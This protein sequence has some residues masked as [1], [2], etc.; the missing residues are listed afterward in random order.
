MK[1]SVIIPVYN[2]RDTLER[3]VRSVSGQ[4]FAD[5]EMILVDDGSSDGSGVLAETLAAEDDRMSVVHQENRGISAARNTGL[6]LAEG[7]RVLFVDSDDEVADGTLAALMCLMDAHPE[8]D[9]LEF[10]VYVHYGHPSQHRFTPRHKV[11]ESS[12]RYWHC[13][14]GWEHA[15][16]WN[17]VFRTE[18]LTRLR[19]PEGRI[20]EDLWICAEIMACGVKVMTTDKGL[21]IYHWNEKGL[22]ASADGQGLTQLLETQIRVARLMRTTLWKRNGWK[23]FRS[24]MYRQIDVYRTTGKVILHFP[25]V[26]LICKLHKLCR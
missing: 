13:T 20:F 26:R 10:P 16:V 11:W 9:V 24:M 4:S 19:F 1:L 8:T 14:E 25:L 18:I 21:Y 17:K 12:S 7:E 5:W 2:V 6:L 22:T 23:L 15:Y 3:C